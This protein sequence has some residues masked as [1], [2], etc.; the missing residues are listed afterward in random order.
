MAK[1]KKIEN[2]NLD[3]KI[4]NDNNTIKLYFPTYNN[5]YKP[6]TLEDQRK[7][8]IPL[9]RQFTKLD[10]ESENICCICFIFLRV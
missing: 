5:L 7:I 9:M 1:K 2:L 8:K 6:S 3:K 10:D 4:I